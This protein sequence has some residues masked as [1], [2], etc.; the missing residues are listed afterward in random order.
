[1][2]SIKTQ[3]P[4]DYTYLEICEPGLKLNHEHD[5]IAELFTGEK[6]YITDYK[7]K[8]NKNEYC[9]TLCAKT[10]S[11]RDY[12]TYKWLIEKDYT[13]NW[14]LDKLPAAYNH[15]EVI[16]HDNKLK[17]EH[18]IHYTSIPIGR[19]EEGDDGE[20][21]HIIYN[22]Y[23]FYVDL[24]KEKAENQYSIVS[25]AVTPISIAQSDAKNCN[26]GVEYHQNFIKSKQKIAVNE[27]ILFTYDIVYRFS[28]Y[29]YSTRWEHITKTT[30][31]K[32]HFYNLINSSLIIVIFSVF[33]LY[34]F[35]RAVRKDIDLYNTK[36][37]SE[38]ILDDSGWKQVCN[39]VFRKPRHSMILSAFIGTGIQLFSMVIF[40]LMFA[41]IGILKPEKRGSLLFMMVLLFVFTGVLNGYISARFFKMFQGT[42]WLKNS[43]FTTFLYPT[44]AFS[45]LLII[46]LS[47][48]MEES[49]ATVF[50]III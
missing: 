44:I 29:K 50:Y 17:L 1:M 12:F 48:W 14:Y 38:D 15:T 47:L 7:I 28:E 32:I 49:S 4:F 10:L 21:S 22:H 3:F 18:N 16:E 2:N 5:H 41:I 27:K 6:Y 35:C 8:I 40:T 19:I 36:V 33:V 24:H 43:L 39:D 37:T 26:D 11:E 13:I 20:F 25:F 9:K 46:N 31:D 23:T 42:E 30:D 45:I 34:I